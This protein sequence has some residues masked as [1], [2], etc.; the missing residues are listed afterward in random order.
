MKFNNKKILPLFKI[1]Y[2]LL[3]ILISMVLIYNYLILQTATL[4]IKEMIA[5]LVLYLIVL[6][7]WYK[8]SKYIEFD[9]A[10]SGLVFI[11][12]GI[13]LSDYI[14]HREHRIELPKEKLVNY[15]VVDRFFCKKV[16]LHIKSKRKVKKLSIDISFLSVNKTKALKLALDKV[17]RENS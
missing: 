14:N 3:L 2:L 10:G 17:V 13:L 11:T 8:I 4:A 9:S 5:L 16:N 1:G 6:G 12:K 15:V 7:Y